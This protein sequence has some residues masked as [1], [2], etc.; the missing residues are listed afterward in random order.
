MGTKIRE[1]IV[2]LHPGKPGIAS[3]RQELTRIFAEHKVKAHWV[4][5][6]KAHKLEDLK[7]LEKKNSGQMVIACGGDGT[8]LQAARLAQ[9]GRLPILGINLGTLGFLA[10]IPRNALVGVMPRVLKGD[11]TV[12]ERL[13][14]DFEVTREGKT[15]GSG[16][17]LNDVVVARGGHSH[18]IRLGLRLSRGHATEYHCDGLILA[19]PTGST[20]YSLSAGGT[21][22]KSHGFRL[23][24]HADLRSFVDESSADYIL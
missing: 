23:D 21:H 5:A 7:S 1:V 2:L 12:S 3:V 13:S 10:T 19:T 4:E 11:Y 24:D 22:Y 17:A 14:L 20:A 8:F 9:G 15:V 6:I 18:M 16:W